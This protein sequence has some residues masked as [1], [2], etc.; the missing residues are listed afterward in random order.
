MVAML[1]TIE[2]ACRRL[3]ETEA[4]D[5]L[6]T[7]IFLLPLPSATAFVRQAAADGMRVTAC[8]LLPMLVYIEGECRRLGETK[9]ADHVAHA[10]ALLEP[11]DET[12]EGKAHP[13]PTASLSPSVPLH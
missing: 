5:H 10:A 9:P 8:S 3:G 2:K 6:A 7:A 12:A 13:A 11:Q 1:H 4:A